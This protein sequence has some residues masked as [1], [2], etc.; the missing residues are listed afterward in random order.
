MPVACRPTWRPTEL[1]A[2]KDAGLDKVH[3]AYQASA[4]AGDKPHLSRAGA[5]LRDRV[6]QRAGR[7]GQE[8]RQPHPQRLASLKNDFGL[9]AK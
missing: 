2:V 4:E 5:D 1:A 3:F 9:A 7:F 6:H 8:S